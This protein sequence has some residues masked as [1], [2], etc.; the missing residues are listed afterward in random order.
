MASLKQIAR[1]YPER[2][3]HLVMDNYATHKRA[4]VRDW[5]AGGTLREFLAKQIDLLQRGCPGYERMVRVAFEN[6]LPN[7]NRLPGSPVDAAS[8]GVMPKLSVIRRVN[9]IAATTTCTGLTVHAELDTRTTP[10]A[11]RSPT[12]RWKASNGARCVATTSTANGT[13]RSFHNA[14]TTRRKPACID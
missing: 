6:P 4:E 11:S 1:A 13:A 10:R 8:A 7:R 2:E 5:L 14:P 9:T 3:L 12:S